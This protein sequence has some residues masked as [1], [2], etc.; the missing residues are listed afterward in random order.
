MQRTSFV[1]V[2]LR[3]PPPAPYM[4]RVARA[5]RLSRVTAVSETVRI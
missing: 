1:K 2:G 5:L 4:R 3:R